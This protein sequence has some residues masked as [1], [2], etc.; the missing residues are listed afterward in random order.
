[1][2]KSSQQCYFCETTEGVTQE[3]YI[4]AQGDGNMVPQQV[5]VCEKCKDEFELGI[6]RAEGRMGAN[7]TESV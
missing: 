5:H 3:V 4:F 1:M 2:E 7:G 6:A